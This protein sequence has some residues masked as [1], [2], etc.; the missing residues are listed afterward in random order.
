M[1]LEL[2]A[3]YFLPNLRF[4]FEFPYTPIVLLAHDVLI[5]S[6]GVRALNCILKTLVITLGYLFGSH[7]P[8][9]SF[10]VFRLGFYLPLFESY[11]QYG[12]MLG[13]S[14]TLGDLVYIHS[15]ANLWTLYE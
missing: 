5:T 3:L 8:S 14:F 13:V 9:F 4:N 7:S 6:R 10:P 12:L 1:R 15:I 2:R 11:V